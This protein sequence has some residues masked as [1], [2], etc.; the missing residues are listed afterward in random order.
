MG[1]N[2]DYGLI[3]IAFG[4]GYLALKS[5]KVKDTIKKQFSD[6][7][8]RLRTGTSKH[9]SPYTQRYFKKHYGLLG[10]GVTE[11][12]SYSQTGEE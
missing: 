6:P 11:T 12:P 2:D 1:N 5:R 10:A 9:Y 8:Y 4:L 3:L 7:L